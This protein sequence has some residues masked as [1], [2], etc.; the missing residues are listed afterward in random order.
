MSDR[1]RCRRLRRRPRR[2]PPSPSASPSG[3]QP[4]IGFGPLGARVRRALA[5]R[6]SARMRSGSG[7]PFGD[8][9][10]AGTADSSVPS[11]PASAA[12]VAS[13]APAPSPR[14]PH[15]PPR[16]RAPADVVRPRQQPGRAQCLEPLVERVLGRRARQPRH[17]PGRPPAQPVE[18]PDRPGLDRRDH[19]QDGEGH[20]GGHDQ[21]RA[22]GQHR[23]EPRPVGPAAGRA[24]RHRAGGEAEGGHDD[25]L[26]Q[27]RARPA[28]PPG[29]GTSATPPARP[30]W[31]GPRAGTAR[32]RRRRPPGSA[33]RAT[34]RRRPRPPAAP[35]GAA[36][37]WPGSGRPPPR[38]TPRSPRSASDV[39]S[40]PVPPATAS[41]MASV[42][43]R[44]RTTIWMATT[45]SSSASGSWTRKQRTSWPGFWRSTACSVETKQQRQH[46]HPGQR[47]SCRRSACG[48]RSRRCRWSSC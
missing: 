4:T 34:A 45:A 37:S 31:P 48:T 22:A 3:R 5:R 13:A 21:Q 27:D 12:P 23:R 39:T 6:V 1:P 9:G 19:P 2:P 16:L 20:E 35:P 46:D 30:G 8:N 44:H 10:T 18:M 47:A 43:D 26:G 7:S 29:A 25:E 11:S 28:S 32:P 38:P 41:L 42:A 24:R 40:A 15:P 17:G 36:R 33:A 14:R